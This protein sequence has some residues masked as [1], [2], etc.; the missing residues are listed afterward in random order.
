MTNEMGTSTFLQISAQTMNKTINQLLIT[1]AL[2]FGMV[3]SSI[4]TTHLLLLISFLQTP[5]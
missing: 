5:N 3:D 1:I 2:K 4:T